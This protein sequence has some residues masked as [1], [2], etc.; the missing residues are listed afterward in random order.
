MD[1]SQ[2]QTLLEQFVTSESLRK[3]CQAVAIC[4]EWQAKKLGLSEAECERW[5]VCGLLHD[6]DYEQFPNPTPDGHPY[7]GVAI[8]REKGVDEEI[9]TAIMGHALYTDTPRTTPMAITLFAVDELSGLCTASVWVRPDKSI[10]NLEVSSVKKKFK[11]KAFAR[12]CNRDDIT[13]GA[14]EM[15]V[16]LEAIIGEVITALRE[17]ADSLGIAGNP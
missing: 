7:Q 1:K 17:K 3:H 13:L 4:M 11:D 12:G 16:E 9:L 6:F 15:G 2:A 10:H 14:K 8:L 5:Y